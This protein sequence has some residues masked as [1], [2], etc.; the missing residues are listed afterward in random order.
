M[1]H[2]DQSA[3]P[4][5]RLRRVR[6]NPWIRNLVAE[7]CLTVNDLIWPIFVREQNISPIIPSLPGILRYTID[8]LPRIIE[9]ASALGISAVAVFPLTCP[10][11]KCS[12]GKEAT[13][14]QNLVCRAL[15]A[16]KQANP[17]IG[18]IADVALDPYT[19]HGHD[20]IVHNG[21]V[22][23]D[24]TLEILCH[25]ALVQAEAGA[26]ILAPSDMMD[27]RIGAIRA[28]LDRGDY[29]NKMILSYAV[30]YASAFYGPFRCAVGA[31]P[32][33][34]PED[35]KTYQM[36][37]ANADE[38]MREVAHDLREGADIIMIKPGLP[39]LDVLYRVSSTFHVPTFAYQVSGE[40]A[41]IKAADSLGWLN[42]ADALM[43]SLM[44][45][46]RA[47]AS[48]ILTY[49]ALE[50]AKILKSIP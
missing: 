40:Y 8:E 24:K 27:G 31:N 43:E 19:D 28:V 39:Y 2:F 29:Q 1:S 13:N 32:L 47:G 5:T 7:S 37:P 17:Q 26:D 33:Q 48:A 42:G 34:G 20:G 15:R 46:K 4:Q 25:Q 21:N 16:I 23:N 49:G 3:F 45:F 50:A 18:L 44:A 6:Q 10:T 30:K 41:S 12:M 9:E 11:L 35:K 36:N 22:D 14:P 38:A